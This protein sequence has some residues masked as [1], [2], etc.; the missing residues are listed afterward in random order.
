MYFCVCVSGIHREASLSPFSG[1]ILGAAAIASYLLHGV[2]WMVYVSNQGHPRIKG[3]KD[4]RRLKK[5]TRKITNPW[6]GEA[7]GRIGEKCF[8]CAFV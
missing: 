6:G 2:I 8:F 1:L 4:T 5:N 7:S 3:I